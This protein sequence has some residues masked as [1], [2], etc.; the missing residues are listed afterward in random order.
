MADESKPTTSYAQ[1][2][3]PNNKKVKE[4]GLGT[5]FKDSV[6]GAFT[7]S[8]GPEILSENPYAPASTNATVTEKEK[9]DTLNL[10]NERFGG[11]G[12]A[13]GGGPAVNAGKVKTVE[14]IKPI[15]S[16]KTPENTGM[17][18]PTPSDFL[19]EGDIRTANREFA[20]QEAER[21]KKMEVPQVENVPEEGG[22]DENSEGTP[23]KGGKEKPSLTERV[24]NWYTDD[25]TGWHSA[26]EQKEID[27]NE[28]EEAKMKEQDA[29]RD[30]TFVDTSTIE[31]NEKP[32]DDGKTDENPEKIPEKPVTEE[33][34][35]ARY[36]Q[37]AVDSAKR[38]GKLLALPVAQGILD[39]N[40][41]DNTVAAFDSTRKIL[42]SFLTGNPMSAASTILGESVNNLNRF[43]DTADKIG[44]RMGIA[45]G[46]DPT[47][48]EGTI[49]GRSFKKRAEEDRQATSAALKVVDD[50][51]V[52]LGED[53]LENLT[54]E[55]LTQF[56][57]TIGQAN[58]QAVSTLKRYFD[59]D[60][61]VTKRDRDLALRQIEVYGSVM[62]DI[63][64]K[65]KQDKEKYAADAAWLRKMGSNRNR[66]EKMR[67]DIEHKRRYDSATPL[68]KM[69][70][71]LLGKNVT[72]N[73]AG[74][75]VRPR[76]ITRMKNTLEAKLASDELSPQDRAAYEKALT[77]ITELA[78]PYDEKQWQK[79]LDET[80]D[81]GRIIATLT[82]KRIPVDK[83]GSYDS[84]HA[85]T[86]ARRAREYITT[87][88]DITDADRKLYEQIA[89]EADMMTKTATQLEREQELRAFRRKFD[90]ANVVQRDIYRI[91]TDNQ[92]KT[93]NL[94]EDGIP[95]APGQ[96]KM[97]RTTLRNELAGGTVSGRIADEF[98]QVIDKINAKLIPEQEKNNRKYATELDYN[99]VTDPSGRAHLKYVFGALNTRRDIRFDLNT[100]LPAFAGDYSTLNRQIENTL[101]DPAKL[102]QMAGS[103]IPD[104]VKNELEYY[105]DN[106]L[107]PAMRKNYQVKADDK[108][109]KATPEQMRVYNL[110]DDRQVAEWNLDANGMPGSKTQKRNL[111]NRI[112]NALLDPSIPDSEK[113]A[114][115]AMRD[116]ITKG[117]RTEFERSNEEYRESLYSGQKMGLAYVYDTLT[118]N[119]HIRFDPNTNLPSSPKD[120]ERVRSSILNA[121]NDPT[122]MS[123]HPDLNGHAAND[124]LQ[125]YLDNILEP[126]MR[127]QRDKDYEEW[128]RNAQDDN[129]RLLGEALGGAK[130][131]I[132]VK[133]DGSISKGSRASAI[134]RV[135]DYLFH[136]NLP[137]DDPGRQYLMDRAAEWQQAI[138]VD[139][140]EKKLTTKKKKALEDDTK[141]IAERLGSLWDVDNV[142]LESVT[143]KALSA[144]QVDSSA[145]KA[146]LMQTAYMKKNYPLVYNALTEYDSID[147][148]ASDG[149]EMNDDELREEAKRLLADPMYIANQH[150]VDNLRMASDTQRFQK[151]IHNAGQALQIDPQEIQR[152][153]DRLSVLSY[154]TIQSK[155]EDPKT[156]SEYIPL[157]ADSPYQKE[158]DALMD[159]YKLRGRFK[160]SGKKG[161]VNLGPVAV[162]DTKTDGRGT[163]FMFS[164]YTQNNIQNFAIQFNINIGGGF[165]G[166]FGNYNPQGDAAGGIPTGTDDTNNVPE[167]PIT[168]EPEKEKPK[169]EAG[170]EQPK[171]IRAN[172]F[173]RY[174]HYKESDDA[175]ED[176]RGIFSSA[177]GKATPGEEIRKLKVD[178][179]NALKSSDI[180]EVKS[181]MDAIDSRLQFDESEIDKRTEF[182]LNKYREMFGGDPAKMDDINK[183]VYGVVSGVPAAKSILKARASL[184]QRYNQLVAEEAAKKEEEERKARRQQ[185]ERDANAAIHEYGDVL[186]DEGFR[187]YEDRESWRNRNMGY[188]DKQDED[189]IDKIFSD[190]NPDVRTPAPD[191]P[192]VDDQTGE[193]PDEQ[194]D[195]T[196]EQADESDETN[197]T[198]EKQGEG[199]QE[200][201]DEKPDEQ[202]TDE[203]EIS[204]EERKQR[205]LADERT[206]QIGDMKKN[207]RNRYL[208][209]RKNHS[210]KDLEM[211]SSPRQMDGSYGT[212]TQNIKRV[213]LPKVQNVKHITDAASGLEK[214]INHDP[215]MDPQTAERYL[216][217]VIED[218]DTRLIEAEI[219]NWKDQAS[220]GIVK[221]NENDIRS[222]VNPLYSHILRHNIPQMI[223]QAKAL[224]TDEDGNFSVE[225]YKNEWLDEQKKSEGSGDAEGTV[226]QSEPETPKMVYYTDNGPA[227]VGSGNIVNE[228]EVEAKRKELEDFDNRIS[229]I[230]EDNENTVSTSEL[231]RDLKYFKDISGMQSPDAETISEL[232]DARTKYQK[233][234]DAYLADATQF[235][236]TIHSS[237]D[238]FLGGRLANAYFGGNNLQKISTFLLD[239][240]K[241][242]KEWSPEKEPEEE[243]K[244]VSEESPAPETP[245][246]EPPKTSKKTSSRKRK[247]Q[248]EPVADEPPVPDAQEVP[249]EEPSETPVEPPKSEKSYRIASP[250]TIMNQSSSPALYEA[251]LKDKQAVE[252]N[253]KT[254]TDVCE[255][256][257]DLNIK[258]AN[259]KMGMEEAYKEIFDKTGLSFKD[260]TESLRKYKSFLGKAGV[261]KE[262]LPWYPDRLGE[263]HIPTGHENDDPLIKR[264]IRVKKYQDEGDGDLHMGTIKLPDIKH[265]E[266]YI[267]PN[268]KGVTDTS[269]T[270]AKEE[271]ER[272]MDRLYA[273]RHFYGITEKG[274]QTRKLKTMFLSSG[275]GKDVTS[276]NVAK[277]AWEM[278]DMLKARGKDVEEPY[279]PKPEKKSKK[280]IVIRSESSRDAL[281]AMF[282][283]MAAEH[284]ARFEAY[285]SVDRRRFMQ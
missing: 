50:A 38:W 276:D 85:K 125:H 16:E 101:N 92:R 119:R 269:V 203:E 43:S 131:T 4:K 180:N 200:R 108:R 222:K 175:P 102:S 210:K 206:R 190:L 110:L 103:L 12:G 28:A 224:F 115:K 117:L 67:R 254:Y 139:N 88:P 256:L 239:M 265:I 197:E 122:Y 104:I 215:S 237:D 285:N 70:I 84:F 27:E 59:G 106:V 211:I 44:K 69:S 140:M 216:Q 19:G 170:G 112:E 185:D 47:L 176:P 233:V 138:D 83:N 23:E 255:F 133:P 17:K 81:K 33:D 277:I 278:Y 160:A 73:P 37:V 99:N 137:A 156:V 161:A 29:R 130:G 145:N 72:I 264:S 39:S 45:V 51:M 167:T 163:H 96:M 226:E 250:E 8:K 79:M 9:N 25:K 275:N 97:L 157:S 159:K 141:S 263:V 6:K 135:Q 62:D 158:L 227:P 221:I 272:L 232:R 76:E 114:L 124:V 90:K 56:Y 230:E 134:R 164:D 66:M 146:A 105:K 193:Q 284:N 21:K 191:V 247:V 94:D 129:V 127:S 75:P 166:G 214:I 86:V 35:T 93:W 20:E 109:A 174:V 223:K 120:Y 40:F 13:G 150:A 245:V 260:V 80:N 55:K 10:V 168:P 201:P 234:M 217:S 77:R 61:T 63:S 171:K 183:K 42:R 182:Y 57:D 26:N 274:S 32:Q 219:E 54:P 82:S 207:R 148:M 205:E 95:A 111:R 229:E 202:Q 271:Y 253:K 282:E 178:S 154:Q 231:N 262:S 152:D 89:S 209:L 113:A 132:K 273:I 30:G 213:H 18:T 144:H 258:V 68:G 270:R 172:T 15:N 136:S 53:S 48:L 107:D 116:D 243:E 143:G 186:E 5:I 195:E 204:E 118:R 196:D 78:T 7:S 246:E 60:E 41:G 177:D 199:E 238:N 240:D 91:L 151:A 126:A 279:L 46:A 236:A 268:A 283:E 153:I 188:W 267:G 3:D 147:E 281:R 225:K 121:M 162:D 181:A 280:N 220:L 235:A 259:G 87:H 218:F 31:Y 249:V 155:S 100:G 173:T 228:E 198:D 169:K 248:V 187:N 165:N 261:D 58:S 1:S 208:K 74:E 24:V 2:K 251:A 65:S 52:S 34:Y 22:S 98:E 252:R 71:D 189:T 14:E 123:D 64:K 212:D 257:I 242:L 192:P 142:A 244:P 36:G 184:Q 128:K 241:K 49:V 194:T 179:E 149:P 266:K 11:K